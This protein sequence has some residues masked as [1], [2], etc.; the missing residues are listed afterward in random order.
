M[1]IVQIYWIFLNQIKKLKN[2]CFKI[3]ILHKI[4][5]KIFYKMYKWIN[6][7]VILNLILIKY[8]KTFNFQSII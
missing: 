3:K 6:K 7:I 5:L 4:I 2:N 8:F 1:I